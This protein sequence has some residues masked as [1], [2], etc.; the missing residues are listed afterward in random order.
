VYYG[1][2]SGYFF[3]FNGPV[4]SAFIVVMKP[5]ALLLNLFVS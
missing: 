5:S 4:C 3:G 2:A 1:G